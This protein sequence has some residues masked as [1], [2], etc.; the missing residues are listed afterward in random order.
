MVA[1]GGKALPGQEGDIRYTQA[2]CP[3]LPVGQAPYV[4]QMV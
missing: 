1:S 3:G 2:T 4:L